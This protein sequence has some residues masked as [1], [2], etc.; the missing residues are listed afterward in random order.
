MQEVLFKVWTR[1]GPASLR[2]P[3]P[4]LYQ[5]VRNQCLMVLRRERRWNET[6][7]EAGV[8]LPAPAQDDDE[9]F[10]LR[11]A[12]RRR[13]WDS[14]IG[15]GLGPVPYDSG[16]RPSSEELLQLPHHHAATL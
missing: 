6:G 2:D 1:L 3:V 4:Y 14:R 12:R 7:I 5:A 13:Q 9:G 16:W 8:A 15:C 11:D 10:D